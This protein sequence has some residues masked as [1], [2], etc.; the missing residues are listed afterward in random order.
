MFVKRNALGDILSISSKEKKGYSKLK[1]PAALAALAKKS[2]KPI[3]DWKDVPAQPPKAD[4]EPPSKETPNTKPAPPVL[5]DPKDTKDGSVHSYATATTSYYQGNTATLCVAGQFIA[6]DGDDL[7][8]TAEDL[9]AGTTFD[10]PAKIR[11]GATTPP[12]EHTVNVTAAHK[13]GAAIRQAIRMIVR[14]QPNTGDVVTTWRF[15]NRLSVPIGECMVTF[16][17]GLPSGYASPVAIVDAHG[18]Q[19]DAQFKHRHGDT[20]GNPR[21]MVVTAV[22]PQVQASEEF[23]LRVVAA[24][25][26]PVHNTPDIKPTSGDVKVSLKLHKWTD[27]GKWDG[28]ED[29]IVSTPDK[30]VELHK[31][32]GPLMTERCLEHHLGDLHPGLDQVCLQY[33]E[34]HYF[35]QS[36]D[37]LCKLENI[38]QDESLGSLHANVIVEVNGKVA[39]EFTLGAHPNM[40]EKD[41]LWGLDADGKIRGKTLWGHKRSGPRCDPNHESFNEDDPNKK[42]ESNPGLSHGCMTT[43][44]A[45]PVSVHKVAPGDAII[46]EPDWDYL[47]S[48]GL[49]PSMKRN[50]PQKWVEQWTRHI[51]SAGGLVGKNYAACTSDSDE[52]EPSWVSEPEARYLSLPEGLSTDTLGVLHDGLCAV[53]ISGGW[54]ITRREVGDWNYTD[55]TT[56]TGNKRMR[57]E[58]CDQHKDVGKYGF[59]RGWEK[60]QGTKARDRVS[61]KS[62]GAHHKEIA[63]VPWW[64]T[65]H[66][67]FEKVIE[68]NAAYYLTH[69][70]PKTR[71]HGAW[72]PPNSRSGWWWARDI[73]HHVIVAGKDRAPVSWEQLSIIATFLRGWVEGCEKGDE[74]ETAWCT[75]HPARGDTGWSGVGM[76]DYAARK[77]RLLGMIPLATL[78]GG[79]GE[80]PQDEKSNY[81][82]WLRA[83]QYKWRTDNHGTTAPHDPNVEYPMA[84]ICDSA[85]WY[86]YAMFVISNMYLAFGDHFPE[87]REVMLHGCRFAIGLGETGGANLTKYQQIWGKNYHD[88]DRHLGL[89]LEP[90]G[91]I[92]EQQPTMSLLE[93]E[94][95][96]IEDHRGRPIS[97]WED[98]YRDFD[99]DFANKNKGSSKYILQGKGLFEIYK[100]L[101]LMRAETK[102]PAQDL[103]TDIETN[104]VHLNKEGTDSNPAM[105]FKHRVFAGWNGDVELH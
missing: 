98:I 25:A 32:A 65:G 79:N 7:T 42:G 82:P 57:Y 35:N 75:L 91:R 70:L 58:S 24:D 80:Y 62:S 102:M 74:H 94:R 53:S 78:P 4:K 68:A 40:P 37:V 100:M 56:V 1:V 16:P 64:L 69:R 49:A 47:F 93:K 73:S 103:I 41:R 45:T 105:A 86:H 92:E 28:F 6:D 29:T 3:P 63:F 66:V 10:A 95:G 31:D 13:N 19:L 11:I 12:G 17:V 89:R 54:G 88:P 52:D 99:W 67:V 76:P 46:V 43:L 22:V 81:P 77:W 27:D 61:T 83:K 59:R 87:L 104:F 15:R 8:Y 26:W 60:D 96:I 55:V 21:T 34:R 30:G 90:F 50:M 39:N 51:T 38:F 33:H 85:L 101:G 14:K 44:T 71:E 2:D 36:S 18:T 97:N 20:A 5:T 48:I 23:A 9:P 84:Y 72:Y